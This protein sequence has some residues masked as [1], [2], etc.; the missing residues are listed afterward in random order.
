MKL[1]EKTKGVLILI[2]SICLLLSAIMISVLFSAEVMS[3]EIGVW[4][5]TYIV[6]AVIFGS[7]FLVEGVNKIDRK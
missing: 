5:I 2:V 7:V 4:L 6:V 1:R 3:P